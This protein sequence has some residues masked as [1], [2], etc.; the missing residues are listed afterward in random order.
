MD[1]ET[2]NAQHGEPKA[3]A[4]LPLDAMYAAAAEGWYRIRGAVDGADLD[5]PGIANRLLAFIEAH[6]LGEDLLDYLTRQQHQLSASTEG[7]G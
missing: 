7:N 6:G 4:V 3:D 5:A 2:V 1:S